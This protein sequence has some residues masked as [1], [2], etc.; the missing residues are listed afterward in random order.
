MHTYD[1]KFR[2]TL[3]AA[4]QAARA[5]S[6]R[7]ETFADEAIVSARVSANSDMEA[8][9]VVHAA[10]DPLGAPMHEIRVAASR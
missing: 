7:F 1:V 4:A 8:L 5:L 10:V 6:G 2:I 3:T 9:E